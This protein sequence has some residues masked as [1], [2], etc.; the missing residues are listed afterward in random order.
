[1]FPYPVLPDNCVNNDHD[2]SLPVGSV[3]E[4]RHMIDV[5]SMYLDLQKEE[6]H[7]ELTLL[8]KQVLSDGATKQL[9]L[10]AHRSNQL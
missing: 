9:Q 8:Q 7:D 6:N 3:Q 2:D 1:M 10:R 4:L 5:P